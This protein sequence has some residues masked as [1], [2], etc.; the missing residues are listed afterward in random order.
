MA[1]IV[2][3]FTIS[4]GSDNHNAN[5]ELHNHCTCLLVV[6]LVCSLVFPTHHRLYT[7]AHALAVLSR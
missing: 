6:N 4:G 7:H 3:L 1:N 2:R 5:G